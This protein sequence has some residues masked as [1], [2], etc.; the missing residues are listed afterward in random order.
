MGCILLTVK[1]SETCYEK[2]EAIR[3][4]LEVRSKGS[5]ITNLK[6]QIMSKS[7]LYS[8]SFVRGQRT[9]GLNRKSRIANRESYINTVISLWLRSSCKEIC[10]GV[11][12]ANNL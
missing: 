3:L 10:T 6:S 4:K 5:E 8:K 9:E 1:F 12:I 11:T 7:S 2:P